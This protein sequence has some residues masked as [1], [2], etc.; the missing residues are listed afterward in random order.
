MVA[1]INLFLMYYRD[2]LDAV[3]FQYAVF[4]VVDRYHSNCCTPAPPHWWSH[5]RPILFLRGGM[6]YMPHMNCRIGTQRTA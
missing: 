5:I 4:F 3:L 6:E 2:A 1:S